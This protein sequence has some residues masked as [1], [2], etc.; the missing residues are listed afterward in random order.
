MERAQHEFLVCLHQDVYLPVGWDRQLLRQLETA[1]RQFG[2]IGVAGV[3]GVGSPSEVQAQPLSIGTVRDDESQ[4]RSESPRYAVDRVGRVVHRGHQL[5]DGRRLPARV[6]T[7]DELLLVVPVDT[8]LRFDPALEFHFYGA[9][10]CLQAEERDLAVVALDAACQHNTDT[11]R[12]TRAFF[13]S[14]DVFARKWAHR[15][16]VA[17]SCVVIDEQR[18]VWVLGSAQADRGEKAGTAEGKI[19]SS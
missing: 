3:Y 4:V 11:T 15:L 1:V 2:P 8:P 16:P 13:R 18:R 6:S 14:A 12:L 7:L 19:E 5:F 17:T 10:I 9:D